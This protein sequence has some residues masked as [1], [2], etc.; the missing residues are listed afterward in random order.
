MTS[1]QNAKQGHM[2]PR[3]FDEPHDGIERE[4]EWSDPYGFLLGGMGEPQK[5]EIAQQYLDAA[6]QLVEDIKKQQVADYTISLPILFLY[7]HAIEVLLKSII[8][9]AWGHNLSALGGKF[10]AYISESYAEAVPEWIMSRLQEIAEIDP[11]STS[12]RYWRMSGNRNDSSTPGGEH[13]ISLLELERGMNELYSA[14]AVVLRV[15]K[16]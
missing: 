12:F 3:I 4:D 13:Y 9:G 16:Q 7:R 6:N 5:P 15:T 10:E 2:R 1:G 11:E 8:P 14:I